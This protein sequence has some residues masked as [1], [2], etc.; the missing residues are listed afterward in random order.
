MLNNIRQLAKL[1]L[2]FS[3]LWI[4]LEGS[5]TCFKALHLTNPCKVPLPHTAENPILPIPDTA[6]NP[7]RL[8]HT[9]DPDTV[10]CPPSEPSF[11]VAYKNNFDTLKCNIQ[12]SDILHPPHPSIQFTAYSTNRSVFSAQIDE[13]A[14]IEFEKTAPYA[15]L[16]LRKTD[17][18]CLHKTVKDTCI[19]IENT[20]KEIAENIKVCCKDFGKHN[21]NQHFIIWRNGIVNYFYVERIIR[22]SSTIVLDNVSGNFSDK[23]K[24]MT[25][26]DCRVETVIQTIFGL[27]S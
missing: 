19:R 2:V 16:C 18:L 4:L 24:E 1:V 12:S 8:P 27:G 9:E 15:T 26:P 6:D 3:I 7:I 10:D 21:P 20:I 14:W 13:V 11:R 25:I 23:K 17:T 5:A 22:S